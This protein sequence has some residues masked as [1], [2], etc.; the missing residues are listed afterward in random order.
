MKIRIK[1]LLNGNN[2]FALKSDSLGRNHTEGFVAE[3]PFTIKGIVCRQDNGIRITGPAVSFGSFTCSRCLMKFKTDLSVAIQVFYTWDRSL[4]KNNDESELI[5][6]MPEE[7]KEIN[8]SEVLRESIIL[9][10]PMKPLCSENCR[11]LCAGCGK[12]LNIDSCN[13]VGKTTDPRWEV[14]AE[15]LCDLE[16]KGVN[17]GSS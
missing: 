1:K 12:N 7:Q 16:K 17:C 11:G 8:L 13:C 5:K 6:Y 14:L 9:S 10:L 3:K 2:D 4:V 15:C